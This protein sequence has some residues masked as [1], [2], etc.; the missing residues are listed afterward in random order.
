MPYTAPYENLHSASF[1][2]ALLELRGLLLEKGQKEFVRFQLLWAG[3]LLYLLL[4]SLHEQWQQSLLSV[5]TMMMPPACLQSHRPGTCLTVCKDGDV[6][7]AFAVL[8]ID[9]RAAQ[10]PCLASP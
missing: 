4:W 5:L 2:L 1:S 9:G 3:L 10:E 8:W 7:Q 6:G